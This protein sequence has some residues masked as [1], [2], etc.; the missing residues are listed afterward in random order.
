MTAAVDFQDVLVVDDESDILESI[1]MYLSMELDGVTVLKA[2]DAHEGLDI[3][4][5]HQVAVVVSDFRMPGM[6]GLE[7]L[8]EVHR[9]RPEL[10]TI[11]MTAYP[12]A[13]LE[14]SAKKDAGVS[15]FLAKPPKM[16]VLVAAIQRAI[17]GEPP[18]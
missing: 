18:T 10:H 12:D 5:D 9:Q 16:D 3:L 14:F 6:D 8:I 11:M 17:N 4:N 13:A 7:F 1:V 15:L 2:H